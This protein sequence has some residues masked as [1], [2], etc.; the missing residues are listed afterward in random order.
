MYSD[1]CHAYELK[2]VLGQGLESVVRKCVERGFCLTVPTNAFENPISLTATKKE[3]AVKIV[4][5][6]TER[7]S[8]GEAKRLSDE[9]LSEVK[10][11]KMLSGHP[12]ISEHFL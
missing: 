5:V 3:Y 8:V 11:L 7:Q 2:E 6:S 1:F 12:S 10:L 4:D 9:T